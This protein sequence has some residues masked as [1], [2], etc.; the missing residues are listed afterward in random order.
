MMDMRFV[1]L[2]KFMVYVKISVARLLHMEQV[3]QRAVDLTKLIVI[4]KSMDNL[5]TKKLRCQ[6]V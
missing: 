2:A 4:K 6:S 5:T 1:A 3:K